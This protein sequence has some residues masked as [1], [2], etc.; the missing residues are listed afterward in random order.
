MQGYFVANGGNVVVKNKGRKRIKRFRPL[1]LLRG[2]LLYKNFK[3]G[4]FVGF[5]NGY[6][7]FFNQN[8]FVSNAFNSVYSDDIRFVNP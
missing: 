7:L 3:K 8:G 6:V 2:C 4:F 1:F 5:P